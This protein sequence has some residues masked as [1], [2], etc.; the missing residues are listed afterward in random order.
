MMAQTNLAQHEQHLKLLESNI[1]EIDD[2]YQQIV[3][4]HQ[5]MDKGLDAI[6]NL[7]FK[8]YLSVSDLRSIRLE[9]EKQSQS[10]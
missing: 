9:L 7:I 2:S 3:D 6:S 10:S 4:A 5:Q 1:K 8:L